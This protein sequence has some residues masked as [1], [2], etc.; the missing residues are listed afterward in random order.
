MASAPAPPLVSADEYLNTSYRPD[1]EY[2][3]GVLVE[4]SEPTFFH[5]LLQIIVGTYLR[6]FEQQYRFKV[7]PELRT[8]IIEGARY[9]I[10]DL[11]LCAT[12]TP[13]KRI[14]TVPPLVVIEVL[15]PDDRMT[16]S[17]ERFRE[18]EAIGVGIIIQMDP[19]KY[20]AHRFEAGSLFEMRFTSLYL[21]HVKASFPF[22]SQALFEQLRSEVSQATDSD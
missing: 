7:L 18:Y 16:E 11:L 20:I 2:V 21:P 3:D 9:R 12:P 6:Q 15:S 4:R 13:K 14:M 19:E 5:A 1:K 10:P 8:Q 17:L 22:D